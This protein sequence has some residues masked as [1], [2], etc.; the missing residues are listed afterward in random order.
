MGG[1]LHTYYVYNEYDQLAFVVPP[2]AAVAPSVTT[3]ILDNLCYQYRYDG[4]NR[5]VE[6]KLPGKGWEYRVYDKADRLIL[7]QDANLEQQGKWMIT[8]Y[9][10]FGRVAYTG[11]Q[12]GGNRMQ[13]PTVLFPG[14]TILGKQ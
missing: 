10:P 12:P 1:V 4:R 11:I 6:K 2:L 9:D 13:N 8:K 7:T 14:L 5:L 3:I